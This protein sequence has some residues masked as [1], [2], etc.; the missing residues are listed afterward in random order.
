MIL[1]L[2]SLSSLIDSS[3]SWRCLSLRSRKARWAA[4]FCSFLSAGDAGL[5][6]RPGFLRIFVGGS[7][8]DEY[9]LSLLPDCRELDSSSHEPFCS[10]A[11]TTSSIRRQELHVSYCS[12][13]VRID[14]CL[15]LKTGGDSIVPFPEDSVLEY[16]LLSG[17]SNRCWM[18]RS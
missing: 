12:P 15:F 5:G 8:D 17:R 9:W 11:L 2:A 10:E 6:F 16:D 4:L 18:I 3:N 14:N 13:W 1:A 7:D